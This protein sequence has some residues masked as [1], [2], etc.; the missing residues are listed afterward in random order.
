MIILLI[1]INQIINVER[2]LEIYKHI[3]VDI[4][5]KKYYMSMVTALF[6]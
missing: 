4:D 6:L 1:F 2:C 3:F 5:I